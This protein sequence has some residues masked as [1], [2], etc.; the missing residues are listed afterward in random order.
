MFVDLRRGDR[1]Q[2]SLDQQQFLTGVI[3][4]SGFIAK[5]I[6]DKCLGQDPPKWTYHG[7]YVSVLAAHF[8]V[9]TEWGSHPL[10]KDKYPDE[11]GKCHA[12]NLA[13]L[14]ADAAWRRADITHEGV[15]YK[16]FPNRHQFAIEFSTKVAWT[17]QYSDVISEHSHKN[18]I[19]KLAKRETSDVKYI[20]KMAEVIM[21]YKLLEFDG[22]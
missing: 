9:K 8:I 15:R 20:G 6:Y 16:A 14:V 2:L 1:A 3:P 13:L 19:T 22:R 21:K 7:M 17:D 12:N 18:Q 11:S 5:L 4:L 10:S